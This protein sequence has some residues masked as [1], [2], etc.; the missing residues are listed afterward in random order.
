[1]ALAGKAVVLAGRASDQD[2]LW[3]ATAYLAQTAFNTLTYRGFSEANIEFLSPVAS[4]AHVDQEATYANAQETFTNWIN[5]SEKLF[6]YLVDHGA[7]DLSGHS[8][9]RLNPAENLP[10]TNLCGWLDDFQNTYQKDVT[11]VIDCCYAAALMNELAYTGT[12]QRVL[13]AAAGTNEPAYFIAG[14][15]V[16]FSDALFSGILSGNDLAQAYQMAQ[17]AMAPYQQAAYADNAGGAGAQGLYLGASFISGKDA[18]QIGLICGTQLLDQRPEAFLW[19]SDIVSAYQVEKV[20]CMII[21]PTHLATNPAAPV[22]DIPEVVLAYSNTVGRYQGAYNGFSAQGSYKVIYYA[23]D[24][25]GSVSA[26]RQ[27]YVVQNGYDERVILVAGGDTNGLT[28]PSLNNL[29]HYAY[30]SLYKRGLSTN[31]LYYLSAQTNQDLTGDGLSDIRAES[32]LAALSYALTSWA[33]NA[34]ALTVYLVGEGTNNT[35]ILNNT[36]TLDA[37]TFDGWLDTFQ[38]SSRV[39]RVILDFAGDGAFVPSLPPPEGLE[40][41]SI[42]SCMPS[43]ESCK[44]AG[45]MISFSRFFFSS[46]QRGQNIC[47]AFRQAQ[48][49]IRR[50]SGAIRQ[51]ALIDDNGNGLPNEKNVDGILSQSRYLGPAFVTG[52]EPPSIG[53]VTPDTELTNSTSLVLWAAEV[54]DAT[55]LSNLWCV[56]TPPDYGWTTNAVETNLAWNAETRR[57]EA[58]FSGFT[59]TGR[60]GCTFYAQNLSGDLSSPKQTVV[61]LTQNQ[62]LEPDAFEPDNQ[63]FEASAFSVGLSQAHTLHNTSDED[64]T[65]FYAVSNFLYDLETV[66]LTNQFDSILEL[67]LPDTNGALHLVDRVDEYGYE[68]GELMGLDHPA[69]GL[70][71]LRV[72]STNYIEPGA[73]T[74][75][76]TP[77]L[78]GGPTD[79]LLVMA[80]N[81]LNN[82]PL[83]FAVSARLH[84]GHS[85]AFAGNNHVEFVGE[86]DGEYTV[87][88]EGVPAG[89]QYVS[90]ASAQAVPV[91]ASAQRKSYAT[92]MLLPTFQL[93][94]FLRDADTGEW[95]AQVPIRAMGLN[96]FYNGLTQTNLTDLQGSFAHAYPASDWQLTFAQSG[97]SNQTLL[98]RASLLAAGSTNNLGEIR[99]APLASSGNGLSDAWQLRYFGATGVDPNADADLDGQN[100]RQEY[101]A[102]TDPTNALSLFQVSGFQSQVS[103]PSSPSLAW[104]VAS[105]RRYSL[106]STPNLIDPAWTLR[107]GPV[108]ASNTQAQMEWTELDASSE[109]NRIYR[110][111]IH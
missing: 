57:Y 47:E 74:L 38:G 106:Y 100:N 50:A 70:Y 20:W 59:L 101:L 66:H 29:A 12:A 53:S 88:L 84:N 51:G 17:S 18:P 49:S 46:V 91:P 5:N 90:Y 98:L 72:S 16:S 8:Y 32:S 22:T 40:R 75:T 37:V 23:K 68:Q 42:A 96:A 85:L 6:V 78:S 35:L 110:I 61:F 48:S 104:P 80:V 89:W 14:G 24:I 36:Q 99:L 28:W 31:R 83:P 11:V 102:G 77:T 76:I 69:D 39:A 58:A 2:A 93:E 95:L 21:S 105:G 15:L 73:Y 86:A 65:C 10:M 111:D 52:A 26:P 79:H 82:Q 81:A 1:M 63:H 56:I 33:T 54:V 41:I 30:Q 103:S 60:Y 34:Q 25:W 64:W 71:Y 109:T 97:Y 13:L 43:R 44:I 4:D 9:F 94:G 92:F 107:Y 27:S 7:R 45:G 55:G 3:P 19:A 108:T 87:T 67:Y 62:G